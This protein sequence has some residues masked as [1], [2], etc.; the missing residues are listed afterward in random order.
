MHEPLGKGIFDYARTHAH[1]HTRT[2]THVNLFLSFSYK[3]DVRTHIW[4]DEQSWCLCDE[5]GGL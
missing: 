1:T 4:L 2:H 5:I 3:Q